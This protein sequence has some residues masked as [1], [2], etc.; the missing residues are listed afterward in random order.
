MIFSGK[1]FQAMAGRP[2]N[3]EPGKKV[4]PTLPAD[5]YTCLEFLAKMRRFG[6]TPSAVARYLI[7]REID[8]LTRSG[9]LPPQLLPAKADID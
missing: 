3:Q 7:L 6:D 4:E 9:V 5:A 2:K 1:V 8:D